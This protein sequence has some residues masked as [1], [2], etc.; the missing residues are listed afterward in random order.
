M[1]EEEELLCAPSYTNRDLWLI[2]NS[3]GRPKEQVC[4]LSITTIRR[5]YEW[6]LIGWMNGFVVKQ[7]AVIVCH[8]KIVRIPVEEGKVLYVQGERNVGKTKTLMSTKAN[9]LTLS[10]IPIV[11]DFEDVFPDDLSGLPPQPQVEFRI[12]F[13]LGATPIAKS[14]YRLA[15]SEMQELSEKL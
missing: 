14:P 3:K 13:I 10:D 4:T 11:C 2:H 6:L 9:E 1:K 7:K 5:Q 12:H 8:E 15:P